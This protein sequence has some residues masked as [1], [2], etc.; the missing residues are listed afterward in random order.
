MLCQPHFRGAIC[1]DEMGTGKTILAILAMHLARDEPGCFSLVIC[2]K[3]CQPQ[4]EAEI[5]SS[6]D[7]V[8]L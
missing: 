3:S 8:S 4:W 1:G 6:Y 7:M 5:E 2:P